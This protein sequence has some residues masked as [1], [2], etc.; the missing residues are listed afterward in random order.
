MK[1][2]KRKKTASGR[3]QSLNATV[4]LNISGITESNCDD[5]LGKNKES[6]KALFGT[7]TRSQGCIL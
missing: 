2:K 6:I 7:I 3:K 5:I 4:D 1:K